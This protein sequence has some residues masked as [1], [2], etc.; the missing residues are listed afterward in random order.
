MA[1]HVNWDY[2]LQEDVGNGTSILVYENDLSETDVRHPTYDLDLKKWCSKW[3]WKPYHAAAISFGRDPE[4]L[5]NIDGSLPIHNEKRAKH[6][7]LIGHIN[8][9]E[10]LI[11]K[12][13]PT[14]FPPAQYIEWAE[15]VG[16]DF[17]EFVRRQ[18]ERV[19]RERE[20]ALHANPFDGEQMAYSAPTP[21]GNLKRVDNNLIKILLALLLET[22]RIK[23][24]PN[25]LSKKL[26]TQLA[27]LELE[28][29]KLTPP[30]ISKRLEQARDLLK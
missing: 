13:L 10:E 22:G 23:A 7:E 1:E 29:D 27:G 15:N 20:S 26:V 4:K 2:W 6:N 8:T 17:P 25:D 9:V 28:G 14:F 5:K 3:Y 16:V 19:N 21:R 18:V 11:Q 30:I 12:Q 24:S